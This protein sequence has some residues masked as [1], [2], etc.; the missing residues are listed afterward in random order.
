VV[1]GIQPGKPTTTEA[2]CN[3]YFAKWNTGQAE[4]A[5]QGAKELWLTGNSQ[6]NA[7][8]RCLAHGAL[9]AR[10]IRWRFWNVF[11]WQ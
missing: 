1:A 4:E 6:P 2:Q 7:C 3:Y 10:K 9:P 11:V 8:D 5:W